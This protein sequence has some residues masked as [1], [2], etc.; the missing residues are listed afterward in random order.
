MIVAYGPFRTAIA[1]WIRHL[2]GAKFIVEIPQLLAQFT[3]GAI[4]ATTSRA[5]A[6]HSPPS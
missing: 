1:A 6:L 3:A 2:I 5:P 4:A